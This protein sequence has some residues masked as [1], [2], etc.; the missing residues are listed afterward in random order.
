[1][2][3]QTP[4]PRPR[5]LGPDVRIEAFARVRRAS[6][7][8]TAGAVAGAVVIAG[9]V[10]DQLPG[11]ASATTNGAPT[12]GTASAPAGGA[13]APSSATDGGSAG[14]NGTTLSPPAS[15]PAPTP[16]A[17]VAVSGGTGY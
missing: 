9:I 15:A 7:W 5:R 10:A 17:P 8:I 3:P 13:S 14:S 6:N 2:A 4:S 12:S 1:M 16:R 11:R